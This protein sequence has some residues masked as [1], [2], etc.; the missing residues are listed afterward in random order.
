M[1]PL[2]QQPA[3]ATASPSLGEFKYP[4]GGAKTKKSLMSSWFQQAEQQHASG[5]DSLVQAAMSE[6]NGEREQL[7]HQPEGQ[8]SPAPALLK[9][10][11]FIHQAESTTS[12]AA[13]EQLHLPLQNNSSVKK[14]WLRQ[15]ISEETT[16]VE[17]IQ[18]Q[19]NQTVPATPSPQP[20]PTVSPL[21][22][23]FST[24]LKK[25]RLVVV[26]NGSNV[27][28][29]EPHIDVIGEPKEEGEESVSMPALKVETEN[30][31]EQDDDV[32]ILRSPSPGTHQIVAEDN[33][34]KIEPEDTSAA[35]DDVKID[36][37]REESQACDKFEEMVKVKR[38]EEEQREQQNQQLL[39]QSEQQAPKVEPSVVEPKVE[40]NIDKHHIRCGSC[41]ASEQEEA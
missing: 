36:V 2:E 7:H 3:P 22:N 28:A 38:E 6:I 20:A 30:Q 29:E 18:Q 1:G 25:R 40:N 5:L 41:S 17:E 32:D 23:G 9:V 39:E 11:Q 16:P 10:E 13:R 15:A 24:P 34:V 12:V 27:E 26:S 14:R 4:P 8:S 37:E 35:A 31:Q 19:Q 21:A 33:L